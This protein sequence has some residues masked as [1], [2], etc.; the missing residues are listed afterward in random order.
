MLVHIFLCHSVANH[1]L[2]MLFQVSHFIV[3]YN[4]TANLELVSMNGG[5]GSLCVGQTQGMQ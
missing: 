1:R 3:K 4:K 2:H 5:E